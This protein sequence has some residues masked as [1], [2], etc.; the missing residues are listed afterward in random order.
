[1]AADH[2][3][4][5]DTGQQV[6]DESGGD[7]RRS[8]ALPRHQSPAVPDCRAPPGDAADSANSPR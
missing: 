7:H 1:M 6:F 2:L 8:L 5:V 4:D 3:D